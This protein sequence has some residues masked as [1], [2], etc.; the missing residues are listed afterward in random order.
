MDITLEDL[1]D[2]AR[3]IF[4]NNLKQGYVNTGDP[5]EDIY[6]VADSVTPT[7]YNDILSVAI[8]DTALTMEYPET[9]QTGSP[10]YDI[11]A[12]IFEALSDDLYEYWYK[13]E[14]DLCPNCNQDITM[15]DCE[16]CEQ[17]ICEDCWNEHNDMSSVELCDDCGLTVIDAHEHA[18]CPSQQEILE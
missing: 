16:G 13:I 3:E 10:I 4:R 12:N 15:F 6:G 17:E 2:E 1:K 11:T 18:E 8:S 5:S 9:G 14:N 7:Y